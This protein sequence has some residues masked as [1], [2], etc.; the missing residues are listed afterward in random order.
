[1]SDELPLLQRKKYIMYKF[2]CAE[3]LTKTGGFSGC[4]DIFAR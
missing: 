1:M 2:M 3:N 4:V